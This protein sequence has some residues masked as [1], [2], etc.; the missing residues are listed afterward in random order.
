V[1]RL[2]TDRETGIKVLEK[3]LRLNDRYLLEKTYDV[4]VGDKILPRKQYPSVPAI[5]TVLE[6]LPERPKART[7]EPEDFFDARFIKQLDETG[8]I[9]SLYKGQKN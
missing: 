4:S 7:A 1:H 5:K 3:Y 9:D 2:K 6:M 8:F